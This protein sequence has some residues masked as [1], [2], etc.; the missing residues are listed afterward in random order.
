[1]LIG[2]LLAVLILLSMVLLAVGVP[3]G[4]VDSIPLAASAL[5]SPG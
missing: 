2:I 5:R 4:P 3:G 1:M